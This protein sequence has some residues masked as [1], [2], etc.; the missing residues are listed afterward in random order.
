[1]NFRIG[2]KIVYPNQ[3]VG[4]VEN[5]STRSFGLAYEKF[6]VLRFV[7]GNATV[8]VPISIATNIGLRRVIKDREISHLLSYLASGP[9][10]VN[11][12][13]KQRYKENTGKMQSGELLQAAEVFK[14]LTQLH[15]DRP[16]AFREKRMMDCARHMLVSEISSACN[17]PERHAAG[18]LEQ[19]LAGAALALSAAG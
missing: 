6:Y 18:M 19:A 13:W 10:P 15:A 14:S 3:G 1:M 12:D 4:T 9:C 11:S 17:V 8:L 5:I 16:L 2:D 7:G